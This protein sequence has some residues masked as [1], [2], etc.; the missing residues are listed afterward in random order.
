MTGAESATGQFLSVALWFRIP[1]EGRMRAAMSLALL[2]LALSACSLYPDSPRVAWSKCTDKST[3]PNS[4]SYPPKSFEDAIGYAQT[5]QDSYRNWFIDEENVSL[6]VGGG[7]LAL[8]GAALGLATAG[9]STTAIAALSVAGGTAIAANQ[10]FLPSPKDAKS[11]AYANGI[12]ELQCV[13]SDA[14]ALKPNLTSFYMQGA[15]PAPAQG[16]TSPPTLTKPS[17]ITVTSSDAADAIAALNNA[18]EVLQRDVNDVR[19]PTSNPDLAKNCPEANKA[20]LSLAEAAAL[21]NRIDNITKNHSDAPQ[22]IYQAVDSIDTAAFTQSIPA[23]PSGPPTITPTST[24]APAPSVPGKTANFVSACGIDPVTVDTLNDDIQILQIELK[25]ISSGTVDFKECIK[26]PPTTGTGGNSGNAQANNAGKS[27][28]PNM[29]VLPS[30]Q[31]VAAPGQTLNLS[32]TGG[33]APYE[34]F[35]VDTGQDVAPTS[36]DG[37]N[38]Q[39]QIATTTAPG[40][41]LRVLA[42]D[43]SG[44]QLPITIELL[45]AP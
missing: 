21:S 24:K 35:A 19:S 34:Q 14:S 5:S 33:S 16:G 20:R 28:S 39:I 6:G 10:F 15:S 8:G 18:K 1:S 25:G 30:Q 26:A 3:C 45:K 27:S 7:A 42:V 41:P 4:T 17:L 13:I 29:V 38:F 9:G 40:T 23:F 22:A 32:I 2:G 11:Q 31:L 12:N 37:A 36:G 43:S 44:S